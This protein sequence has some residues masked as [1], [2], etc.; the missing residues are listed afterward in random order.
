MA[1]RGC[2]GLGGFRSFLRLQRG[3]EWIA[4]VVEVV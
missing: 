4:E 2:R 3:C 1:C